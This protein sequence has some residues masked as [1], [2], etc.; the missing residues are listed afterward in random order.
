[1]KNLLIDLCDGPVITPRD[2]QIVQNN[3]SRN[4]SERKHWPKAGVS[5]LPALCTRV[6]DIE[7]LSFMRPH[8][9]A[10]IF[11]HDNFFMGENWLPRNWLFLMRKEGAAL[12]GKC[13]QKFGDLFQKSR[14]ST[15]QHSFNSMAA[16]TMALTL[17]HRARAW[18][19]LFVTAPAHF[20]PEWFYK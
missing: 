3:N 10:S 7:R 13:H 1:M 12:R 17:R 6:A 16:Q 8:F 15:A 14:I 19:L 20:S 11:T 9:P 4:S 5:T 18:H 2:V